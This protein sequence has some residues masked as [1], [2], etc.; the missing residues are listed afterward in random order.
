[1]KTVYT[2]DDLKDLLE[3][4]ASQDPKALKLLSQPMRGKT[5]QDYIIKEWPEKPKLSSEDL[6]ATISEGM[7]NYLKGYQAPPSFRQ[8]IWETCR[9]WADRIA[10]QTGYTPEYKFDTY[11]PKPVAEDTGIAVSKELHTENGVTKEDLRKNL[12]VDERTIRNNL[13]A[14][15][16][17]L[18][19][20]NKVERPL[21]IGGQE[22]KAKVDVSTDQNGRKIYRMKERLH[23][24]ILQLNTYQV[25]NLLQALQLMNEIG[26]SNV[27]M[28]I[29]LDIWYQLSESGKQRVI[30]KGS[31]LYS[32]FSTFAE[33]LDSVSEGNTLPVFRTESELENISREDE[34]S[35]AYKAGKPMNFTLKRNGKR[36]SYS[37]YT[38]TDR[39]PKTGIWQAS[40]ATETPNQE[41]T[42]FFETGDVWGYIERAETAE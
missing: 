21:R 27:S 37:H 22:L 33:E 35:L 9:N 29:A 1:M 28:D 14:L 4:T 6:Y 5:I 40:C 3:A 42:I 32:D 7:N 12:G 17:E 39:D 10:E 25:C 2:K 34:L 36:E 16:P 11:A 24:L 15:C 30:E 41:N 38:I 20:G 26:G 23:P 13:R 31:R 8:K 18:G 19:E